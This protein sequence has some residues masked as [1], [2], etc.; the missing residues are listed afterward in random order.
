MR[1]IRIV[2]I[3]LLLCG[4]AVAQTCISYVPAPATFP[5]SLTI[6]TQVNFTFTNPNGS[7][8][9]NSYSIS[10]P[11]LF[12]N[13]QNQA[14]EVFGASSGSVF[15][16]CN[17]V[18][19]SKTGTVTFLNTSFPQHWQIT[20][21]ITASGGTMSISEDVVNTVIN[22]DGA[23]PA[24]CSLDNIH[25]V[26]SYQYNIATGA[27]T[28]T[29]QGSRH[30]IGVDPTT[31]IRWEQVTQS[32]GGT[33]GVWPVNISSANSKLI[34]ID[35]PGQVTWTEVREINNFG[36]MAGRYIDT[37][38]HA[39]TLSSGVFKNIDV[40]GA[41][42]TAA[43]GIN[44]AGDVVGRYFDPAA[45]RDHGFLLRNGTYTTI[46][47]PGTTETFALGINNLGQIVG[48]YHD[49]TGHQHGFLLSNGIYTTVDFPG[50]IA[51]EVIKINDVGT[52]VGNYI[53]SASNNHGF[54]LQ[55]GAFTSIDVPGASFTEVYGINNG[56]QIAGGYSIGNTPEVGFELTNGVVQTVTLPAATN[57]LVVEDIND[58]AQLVGVYTDAKGIG[59]GFVSARGPF[60]YATNPAG[61]NLLVIDSAVNLQLAA[62]PSGSNNGFL[63]ASPDQ[64]QLYVS[65]G[66]QVNVIDTASNT[67]AQSITVGN[68]AL[69]VA[70]TP[71]GAFVYVANQADSTVSV[72]DAVKR[73]VATTISGVPSPI[74]LKVSPD[75][76]WVYVTNRGANGSVTVISTATNTVS[77]VIGGIAAPFTLAI[78]P[79]GAYVYLTAGTTTSG[80]VVVISMAT[81]SIVATIPVGNGPINVAF[82]PD[83]STAYVDNQTDSTISIIDT[84][85][86]TVVA[87]IPVGPT[88]TPG[89]VVVSPD[90][91]SLYLLDLNAI[92]Q[93]STTSRSVVGS[94][95]ATK[96]WLGAALFLSSPPMT[97]TITL[98]LSA[99]A[100]TQFNF[101]PHNFTV[102]FPPGTTFTGVNMT[103]AAAQTTQAGFK[104][105]V[106]GSPFA[107]ASCIV[108]SGTGGNCVN[109]QVSCTDTSGNP[110]P[111]PSEPTPTINIKTS[112]DTVQS[113]INPGFLHRPTGS[114]Q[115]ENIFTEFLAQ[116]IDPTTKGKSKGFSDFFAVDLGASNA[117]GAGTM[118]LSA[119]LRPTDPRV[120]TRG[121]EINVRFQLTSITN[122]R[123]Y[124]SD[125]QAGMAIVMLA[126]AQGNPVFR[127]ML[128]LPPPAFHY[129]SGGQS[130]S[131]ELEFE[132][133]RPGT[134]ALTIYG[135][136][137]AAQQVLFTVK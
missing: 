116:R 30:F 31:G 130:Y 75:G 18:F 29:F 66:N 119:P 47:P 120:F 35:Y 51:S 88:G 14:N 43:W 28:I 99:T 106:S 46:D 112:Y 4:A 91:S 95:P 70:V 103:V 64:T 57:G 11:V 5:F 55:N 105:D 63:A 76:Q 102:Q 13:P 137:F 65:T 115:F 79:D 53:D 108:Y 20:V 38:I 33:S 24:N 50:E 118:Q 125:A 1:P 104:Q 131:R 21:T 12:P 89:W 113:I 22:A 126:D 10:S 3:V 121:A 59:H 61:N 19:P 117:Q 25:S 83:G 96:I 23:C 58:Q 129:S 32:Q 68:D 15:Q 45:N 72:I 16:A 69:G 52:M 123:T 6:T 87:T 98:P 110:I 135:N 132:G 74:D 54:R 133:F 80:S 94:I 34:T 42:E 84:A 101:G 8:S 111:C 109:Y 56:G 67:L 39:F 136:A 97:Q 49:S 48:Y 128:T 73:T 37:T 60:L 17:N 36:V 134:Y 100:P 41:T 77:T 85:T 44:D 86:R 9:T 40:A 92:D 62:I 78:T 27:Y 2:G 71:N 93:I 90:G 26:Y 114:N 82:S 124:I 127:E 7:V 81:N 107:N 122:P